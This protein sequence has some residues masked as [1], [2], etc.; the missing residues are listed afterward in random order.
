VKRKLGKVDRRKSRLVVLGCGQREG[1]DYHETFGPVAKANTIRILLA[2]ALANSCYLLQ[3]DV[4]TAFLYAP[5][6]EEIYMKPPVGMTGIPEGYCLKLKKSLYGL[7]QAPTNFNQHIDE[8]IRNM[9][10]TSCELDNCVYVMTLHD[11]QIVLALYADNI[12]LVGDNID[13]INDVKDAFKET[14]KMKDL[15][16][17]EYYLGMRITRIPETLKIDQSQYA[18]DVVTKFLRW[19]S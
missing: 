4:D 11:C 15:G 18:V 16:D 1:I 10:F 19:M 7:K 5:L 12:V 8:F 6:E 13:V 17:L 9:G 14:F 3:I 2:L